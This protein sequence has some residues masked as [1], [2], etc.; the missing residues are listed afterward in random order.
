MLSYTYAYCNLYTYAYCNLY[1][2]EF[3]RYNPY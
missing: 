2:Y 1:T 3:S